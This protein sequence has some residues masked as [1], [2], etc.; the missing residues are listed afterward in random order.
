M[1]HRKLATLHFVVYFLFGSSLVSAAE[2]ADSPAGGASVQPAAAANMADGEIVK[3]EMK[4]TAGENLLR[5]DRF[6]PFMQGFKQQG[7]AFFC[8]DSSG[9]RGVAQVVVLNQTKPEPITVAAWSKAEG[10]SGN[11]DSDYAIYLDLVYDDNTPLFGQTAAFSAGTHDWERREV[12]VL[13]QRPVKSVS[14][15][16]LLRNHRGKAWF[17]KPS[18]CVNRASAGATLFDQVAVVNRA[19]AR[20]G[21][22]VRDVAARSGFVRLDRAALGLSLECKKSQSNGATFFDV[23]LTDTTG[24]DRAVTLVYAVPV[25]PDG[26]SWHENPRSSVPVKKGSE[27]S[28]TWN[29]PIGVGAM[30][31]YP[32]GCVADAKQGR[33][34]GIDMAKPAVY[35]I[36]YHAG[37][38]E[39]FLSYDLGLTPE[40]PSA[41]VRFCA[42][43]FAP[44]WGFRGALAAY[45]GHFPEAF[46][47]RAPKQGLWMPFAPISKV[48]GFEDFGFR[49]KEGNDEIVWDDQHGVLTFRYTEPMT[50]WMSMDKKLPRTMDAAEA[51]VKR[52]AAAGD[53]SA[54]ALLASGHYD[55]NGRLAAMLLDTPWCNGAVWSMNSMPKI[56]GDP[57]DFKLKWNDDARKA[58]ADPVEKGGLDGEYI[59]SSEG[60]VTRELD[61]RRDHFAAAET[62]LTFDR[63]SRRPG[64]FRGLIAFEYARA[65]AADVHAR[66]R[67]MMSNATPG[68]L[69]WLTPLNDVLG[70]E[71]DWNS[72]GRWG[73][74]SDAEMLYRR[75]L[76]KGKP[77]CFLMNT[78]FE[79]FSREMVEKYMKRSLA[80]GM[81]PGFFSADASTGAYFTR[82]ELYERDRALFK[83]YVPLCK[84]VAES[85]WEP[86]T[87]ARSSDPKVYVERFGRKGPCYLTVFN[88][89]PEQRT[90]AI[91]LDG[92]NSSASSRE[93]VSG[94]EIAW[95]ENAT[96]LTLAGED[97]AV[98]EIESSVQN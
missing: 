48:K 65:I 64:I 30:S 8:D 4:A 40:K 16:L 47:C 43:P 92:V 96:T 68:S 37:T 87:R 28:H 46:D 85:G 3:A 95:K 49:F 81:F 15:Y 83:K 52:L 94:K 66:H 9:P 93:L 19:P 18:L 69:C 61:F 71:T 14:C 97:V 25:A 53:R 63:A 13:P 91:T 62:P 26:L 75:A 76:C 80:Y 17:R 56:A 74:M 34:I 39:L 24:S 82:P 11:D 78:N 77:Y 58:Y 67:L 36:G 23:T 98:V 2:P 72:G 35:R 90:A 86:I 38:G 22:Q 57:T 27:Y 45:Y 70:T 59:D 51:E 6:T 12:V 41:N 31:R 10:V 32:L 60:Y 44:A 88:D 1:S 55:Q 42:F 21:F 54:K 89:S 20:A 84:T 79:K 50:W 29:Q 33:A 73:P 5:P 7:E